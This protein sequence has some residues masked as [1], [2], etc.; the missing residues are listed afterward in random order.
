M[1]PNID[2]LTVVVGLACLLAGY[3]YA[4]G[5]QK[6]QV[7]DQNLARDLE[8]H[9]NLTDSLRQDVTDLRAK[10]NDLLEKNWQLTQIKPK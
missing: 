9:R 1:S 8:Y 6:P 10:N 7:T 3:A 4:V 5:K 2:L